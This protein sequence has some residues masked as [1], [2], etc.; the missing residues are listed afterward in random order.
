MGSSVRGGAINVLFSM[1]GRLYRGATTTPHVR[2][3]H[4]LECVSLYICHCDHSDS[5]MFVV[6]ASEAA[7]ER[8]ITV[9]Q[10]CEWLFNLR[11]RD[12]RCTKPGFDALEAFGRW[13]ETMPDARPRR[14]DQ[15]AVGSG[16][17]K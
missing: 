9:G 13:L 5:S 3:C 12:T 7:V 1:G 17:K 6:V 10:L 11:E 8:G 15:G 2:T 16:G 4:V 14:D